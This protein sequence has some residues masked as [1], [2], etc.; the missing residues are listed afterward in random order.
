[1][2]NLQGGEIIIDGYNTRDIGLN[3]LRSSLALV[4]Q[5]NTLFSGSLRD[6]LWVVWLVMHV[7]PT[8]E[9][10]R[11]DPQQTR[12]DAEL[13]SVLHRAGIT[14]TDE[15]ADPVAEAKFGLYSVVN[16]EGMPNYFFPWQSIDIF[17]MVRIKLQRGRK[18][19]AGAL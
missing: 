3:I 14:T 10:M 6:N 15:I 5:D 2:V 4:P 12:T 1:M 8:V 17:I 13:M 7:V 18:A 19:T 16:D 11:R 9:M